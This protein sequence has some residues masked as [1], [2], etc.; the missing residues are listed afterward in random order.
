MHRV[1]DPDASVAATSASCD[2]VLHRGDEHSAG[3]P[4]LDMEIEDDTGIASSTANPRV[5][6]GPFLGNVGAHGVTFWLQ[7]SAAA[8]W[9]VRVWPQGSPADVRRVVA[10]AAVAATQ[11]VS[12]VDVDGL[13]PATQYAY[14]VEI[15]LPGTPL[16][17][18]TEVESFHTL[19][20]LGTPG[21]L[22]IVVGADIA[23]RYDQPIFDQMADT[24]PDLALFLGDQVYADGTA[25]DFDG[26]SRAYASN[27]AIPNL[28]R[29]LKHVPT[30]MIWDDHEIVDDYVRGASERYTPAR[31]AYELYVN[32]RNPARPQRGRLYYRFD[33]GDVS[34]FVLD[35]RTERDP[36]SEADGPTKSMLGAEQKRE[37]LDWLACSHARLKLIASPVTFSDSGTTGEDG[38]AGYM[39]ERE[40]IFT[41]IATHAIEG[42]LLLSGDQHWSAVFRHDRPGYRLFEFM[43][44]PISKTLRVAPT[45]PSESIV[46]RDDDHYVFGVV[47]VDSTGLPLHVDLTLC[48][49]DK[50]CSP[51][52]EPEPTTGL[53]IDGTQDN[54]PFTIHLTSDDF[55]PRA[56]S[57]RD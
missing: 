33:A 44:T 4:E 45:D 49:A 25:V 54:V 11:F 2:V 56:S 40:E 13:R 5:S 1:G 9:A 3:V 29:F 22:R 23:G 10:P 19:A 17:T 43:P 6:R 42:V 55:G 34:G 46:A 20:A 14:V 16:Q 39:H 30:F 26:Y 48:A 47:D 41:F 53:D 8:D 50:P 31:Q 38:W 35:V 51:G 57:S 12:V 36:E 27:W 24:Q 28:A 37:L 7:G 52:R 32:A 15:G 21:T 18:A